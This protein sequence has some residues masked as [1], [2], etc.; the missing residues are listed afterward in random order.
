MCSIKGL[1]SLLL[2]MSIVSWNFS[3]S[4]WFS[5]T[6]ISKGREINGRISCTQWSDEFHH[7]VHRPVPT[8]SLPFRRK[9]SYSILVWRHRPYKYTTPEMGRE[10]ETSGFKSDVLVNRLPGRLLAV[11]WTLSQNVVSNLTLTVASASAQWSA[12]TG[13]RLLC[14]F[15]KRIKVFR[16]D[17]HGWA[18]WYVP[19]MR[20]VF[21]KTN[22]P[23]CDNAQ[24]AI[25]NH[26][27]TVQLFHSC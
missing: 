10:P 3:T 16:H 4:N 9:S 12:S 23:S 24:P 7:I 26:G 19:I 22:C 11:S 18:T 5:Q 17:L 15:L 14:R 8:L 27:I 13:R 1:V 25:K 6:K 21:F 20:A 2:S